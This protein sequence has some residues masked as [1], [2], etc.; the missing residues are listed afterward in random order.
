MKGARATLFF[1]SLSFVILSKKKTSRPRPSSLSHSA[2]SSSPP[3]VL[4]FRPP[5][6]SLADLERSLLSRLEASGE[7]S[8]IRASAREAALKELDCLS[9]SSSSASKNARTKTTSRNNSKPPPL[10]T[11]PAETVVALEL[12]REFLDFHGFQRARSLLEAEADLPPCRG[13]ARGGGGASSSFF[14]RRALASLVG[15]ERDGEEEEEDEQGLPQPPLLYS[16]MAQAAAASA[17]SKKRQTE[18]KR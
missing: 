17:A 15:V 14:G 9:S 8:R 18:E 16:V 12:V 5:S 13:R 3:L 11:P 6:M 10:P 4:P 2:V 1:P 7:L